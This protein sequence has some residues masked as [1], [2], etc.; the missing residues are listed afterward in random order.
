MGKIVVSFPGYFSVYWRVV[1][2]ATPMH[3]LMRTPKRENIKEVEDPNVFFGYIVQVLMRPKMLKAYPESVIF[4]I[5]T[6]KK[7]FQAFCFVY[8]RVSL[9]VHGSAYWL[10]F[11]KSLQSLAGQSC[12]Q[13]IDIFSY[14]SIY[15][16]DLSQSYL[17]RR[18]ENDFAAKVP[19][20]ESNSS[21]TARVDHFPSALSTRPTLLPL[22][23]I[24]S[25]A[26]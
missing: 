18:K 15:K 20:W 5:A 25:L 6:L 10:V 7:R 21:Y 13:E 24:F 12:D 1:F 17:T 9:R 4:H 22:F 8:F 26:F 23:F 11:T 14:S 2:E 16:P 19:E 3:H